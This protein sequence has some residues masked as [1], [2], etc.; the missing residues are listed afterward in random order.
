VKLIKGF[1]FTPIV[2]AVILSLSLSIL[3]IFSETEHSKATLFFVG[4]M[5]WFIHFLPVS[6]LIVLLVG[7]PGYYLMVKLGYSTFQQY[8]LSGICIGLLLPLPLLFLT[9]SLDWW[10]WPVTGVLGGIASSVFWYISVRP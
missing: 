2:L 1:I 6:F 10:V 5:G 9:S 4:L 8:S 3:G 7:I